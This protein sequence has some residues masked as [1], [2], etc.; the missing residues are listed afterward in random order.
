MF[1]LILWKNRERSLVM[2]NLKAFKGYRYNK[3]KI[4]DIGKQ[5]SPPYY[6]LNMIDKEKFYKASEFNSV[7]LFCG[8]D[9]DGDT[10]ENNRFTRAANYL[11]TWIEEGILKRDSEEAIYMYEQV[12]TVD[13]VQYSN[14][15][16]VSLVELQNLEEGEIM[17]C[18]EIREVSKQDRYDFLTATN[19]D[20]SMVSCLYVERE[21]YLF[22]LMNKIAEDAPETE[23]T[24]IDGIIHRI[25]VI[26][27]K[28]K[29][30]FIVDK[31]KD[32]TLYITDGQTRYQTCLEYR[33][34]MRA[35]NPNHTGKEPYNYTMV[36]LM[37]SRSDGIAVLPMH[38]GIKLNRPFKLDYFVSGAQD[39]FK[40]EKIIVDLGDDS[41]VDTMR[42]QIATK[43]DDTK[44]AMY[45]G[46]DFFYRITLKDKDYLKENILPD[47]SE[48]YCGLDI[49]V[50]NKLV[51][52]DILM[53]KPEQFDEV[54]I[55]ERNHNKCYDAVA[56]GEF[57]A[58]FILN[59]VKIEQI[60]EVTANREKM[61][62]KTVC[63]YPKP[64]VGVVIN[65]KE[66]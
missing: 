12:M 47:K 56:D 52:E 2:A 15:S 41:F 54:V 42:K 64:A 37:N 32:L 51:L 60:R 25:W 22:N 40:I 61:P 21:K 39:H 18:E 19:A 57:S 5:V 49:V 62:N 50:L 8:Q 10:E 59:P 46:G 48:E 20:L 16:F 26:T 3:E 33:N 11:S 31:F 55:A 14:R 63:V 38:R 30:D 9:Y 44:I 13:G 45:C 4:D 43:R 7:R 34:Y 65:I 58:M 29:I 17:S 6:N 28:E 27:D 24:S 36:S 35:N 53:I 23:Y 1:I 66:D